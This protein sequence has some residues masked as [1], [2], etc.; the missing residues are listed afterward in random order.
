[1]CGI[2]AEWRVGSLTWWDSEVAG[3]TRSPCHWDCPQE[4]RTC[5]FAGTRVRPW[6]F[7]PFG[8]LASPW[9]AVLSW[10][11]GV[12]D[13]GAAPWVLTERPPDAHSCRGSLWGRKGEGVTHACSNLKPLPLPLLFA[14][15]I[16][17]LLVSCH[18]GLP[19]PLSEAGVWSTLVCRE[20]PFSYHWTKAR[21]SG[22]VLSVLVPSAPVRFPCL[23]S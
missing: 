16:C 11:W 22:P 7:S 6:P 1:M 3:D 17:S 18:Q 21:P 13:S 14:L 4:P 2:L 15:G 10:D 5:W 19:E 12:C 8:I 9:S 20:E 23:D